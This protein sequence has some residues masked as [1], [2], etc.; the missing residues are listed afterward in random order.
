MASLSYLNVAQIGKRLDRKMRHLTEATAVA[1]NI[2]PT[3]PE[4]LT[5]RQRVNSIEELL[6]KYDGVK[7]RISSAL[8]EI[9]RI[10]T[11]WGN[12]IEAS[13]G[14]KDE[15]EQAKTEFRAGLNAE[16]QALDA[17]ETALETVEGHISALNNLKDS[18]VNRLMQEHLNRERTKARRQAFFRPQGSGRHVNFERD[19]GDFS[20]FNEDQEFE[21]EHERERG[22]RTPSNEGSTAG[23]DHRDDNGGDER[24]ASNGNRREGGGDNRGGGGE[25]R[26]EDDREGG[27]GHNAGDENRGGEN[28]DG[29]GADGGAG[30]AGG[31]AGGGGRGRGRGGTFSGGFGSV[32]GS[33]GR[34]TSGF[35][36]SG[37]SGI[38]DVDL[39]PKLPPVE[40]PFFSGSELEWNQFWGLFEV[41]IDSK[42]IPDIT[43]LHY[44]ITHLRGDAHRAVEGYQVSDANYDIIVGVL[45]RRFGD[46]ENIIRALHQELKDL[47]KVHRETGLKGV[48]N[49]FESIQRVCR[50]MEALGVSTENRQIRQVIEEKVPPWLLTEAYNQKELNEMRDPR[51]KWG[52]A[53]LR[54]AIEKVI[55]LREKVS[56]ANNPRQIGASS[57]KPSSTPQF[58]RAGRSPARNV[59]YRSDG[60]FVN[61]NQTGAFALAA[62]PAVQL[63]CLFRQ[64]KHRSR[65]CEQYKTVQDRRN[66][67]QEL[68][69]CFACLRPSHMARNCPN[70]KPCRLCKSS[71]HHSFLCLR[72]D[73]RQRSATRSRERDPRSR[74]K[75]PGQRAGTPGVRRVGFRRN[76]AVNAVQAAAVE[77]VTDVEDDDYEYDPPPD[78]DLSEGSDDAWGFGT[79]NVIQASCADLHSQSSPVYLPTKDVKVRDPRQLSLMRDETV[80]CDS[81]SQ[82]TFIKDQLALDLGLTPI[83]ERTLN[84]ITLHSLQPI[85][86]VSKIYTIEIQLTN[87]SFMPILAYSKPDL[88]GKVISVEPRPLAKYNDLNNSAWDLT[89]LERDPS[90]LLGCDVLWQLDVSKVTELANGAIILKSKIGHMAVG[91]VRRGNGSAS[92]GDKSAVITVVLA[93]LRATPLPATCSTI[94]YAFVCAPLRVKAVENVQVRSLDEQVEFHFALESVG[95]TDCPVITEH[96][97]AIDIFNKTV[98]YNE[99]ELRYYVSLLWKSGHYDLPTN[100]RYC[101]KRLQSDWKHRYKDDLGCSSKCAST[102]IRCSR[103]ALSVF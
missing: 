55:S 28:T 44:L 43:K 26:G 103:T 74:S 60:N 53:E 35:N 24:D 13:L 17:A 40:L 69:L 58:R 85:L 8:A 36:T 92:T 34:R 82:L 54:K 1:G 6:T 30:G 86:H 88:I 3:I 5:D 20:G 100:F 67:A 62:T 52:T 38:S 99:S 27:G 84:I 48:R 18:V 14:D 73:P 70:S 61:P 77:V 76:E 97:L 66:R 50:Q 46:Q 2:D 22:Y 51:Y 81:G 11:E 12:Q 37:R 75:S 64:S 49:T 87:G 98:K 71:G 29:T 25:R 78:Y 90:I 95:I 102:L 59:R 65:D 41:L 89:Y 83:G 9:P 93:T 63:K 56:V 23:D 68:E 10:R 80:V 32:R 42:P 57:P 31:S 96:E 7:T 21:N 79:K 4:R 72:L 91:R 39:Q 45:K 15:S 101:L 19:E 16:Q 94:S 47:P 33:F